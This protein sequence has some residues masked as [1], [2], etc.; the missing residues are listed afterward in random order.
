MANLECVNFCLKTTSINAS[1]AFTDYYNTTVQTPTGVISNNRKT[2]T[3]YNVNLRNLLG[4][5][6]DKY[7]AFNLC[8]NSYA[9]ST[10]GSLAITNYDNVMVHVYL[11]GLSFLSSNDQA[12]GVSTSNVILRQINL[13]IGSSITDNQNFSDKVYFTFLKNCDNVNLTIDLKSVATNTYPTYT[14]NTQLRGH[15]AFNFSIYGV[16]EHRVSKK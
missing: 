3:W 12:I 2:M 10:A 7:K 6:Y 16:E 8:L 13:P 15:M 5:M 11:T 9:M 14:G 1:T 4:P